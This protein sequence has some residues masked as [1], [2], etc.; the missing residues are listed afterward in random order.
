MISK[1][2]NYSPESFPFKVM[3]EDLLKCRL[4]DITIDE[5]EIHWDAEK[6]PGGGL[7]PLSDK[8]YPFKF[9]SLYRD[10][11]KHIGVEIAQRA[12]SVRIVPTNT[13]YIYGP[14]SDGLNTHRDGDPPYYHPS[15]ETN[16]WMPLTHTD[17]HNCLYIEGTPY[18]LKPGQLLVFNGN[19]Q[20]HGTPVFNKSHTRV[21]MDFR[22]VKKK[23]YNPSLLSDIKIKSRGEWFPQNEYFTTEE[24]YTCV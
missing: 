22:C 5:S 23:D 11:L 3:F 2:I 10:F 8:I 20:K 19:T 21:S 15:W 16:Y 24:Y 9:K 4:E 17:K 1:I 13:S 18:I 12:P 14:T 6:T 7:D